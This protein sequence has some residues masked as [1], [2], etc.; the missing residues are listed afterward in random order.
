MDPRYAMFCPF[1]LLLKNQQPLPG[2]LG[3]FAAECAEGLVDPAARFDERVC[4]CLEMGFALRGGT[5]GVEVRARNA[6]QS[7]IVA[8][9]EVPRA[10]DHP[11][12]CDGEIDLS[13]SVLVGAAMS[14]PAGVDRKAG[15]ADH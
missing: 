8:D 11:V 15:L 13:R 5:D 2:D 6:D 1:R 7:V 9:D 3:I 10:D 14:D 4:A 12:N